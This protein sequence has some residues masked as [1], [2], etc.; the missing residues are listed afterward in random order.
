MEEQRQPFDILFDGL[1][2][3]ESNG[4]HRDRAGNLTNSNLPTDQA[5]GITQVRVSTGQDP[6]FGV[7]PI[8]NDSEEEY[9]RFGRDYLGAM[10]REYDNDPELAL[11]AYNAGTG[12][13]N[14]AIAEARARGGSWKEYLPKPSETLPYIDKIMNYVRENMDVEGDE[15]GFQQVVSSLEDL[16]EDAEAGEEVTADLDG[17]ENLDLSGVDAEQF[18]NDIDAAMENIRSGTGGPE[19][20]TDPETGQTFHTFPRPRED[21]HWTDMHEDGAWLD[22]SELLYQMV[23]G[24]PPFTEEFETD[25]DMA[26]WGLWYMSR[27]DMQLSTLVDLAN[28][29]TRRGDLE[30][31][32]GLAYMIEQSNNI[33]MSWDGAWR[34]TKA[35]AYDPVNWLSLTSLIGAPVKLAAQQATKAG[36]V[37]MLKNSILSRTTGILAVEA[38]A[39]NYAFDAMKQ[40]VELQVGLREDRDYWQ[41]SRSGGIGAVFGGVGGTVADLVATR[42][43]RRV[44]AGGSPRRVPGKKGKKGETAEIIPTPQKG[45]RVEDDVI[46]G[47]QPAS[48]RTLEDMGLP[49][50][51]IQK[52]LRDTPK[53]L[54]A[55]RNIAREL[56]TE[57][58]QVPKD[59]IPMVAEGI[60]RLD[61]GPETMANIALSVRQT[62]HQ[63]NMERAALIQSKLKAVASNSI[64][65]VKV[66]QRQLDEL[67]AMAIPLNMMDEAF[68]SMA[69]STLRQRVGFGPRITVESV[70]KEFPKKTKDEAEAIWNAAWARNAADKKADVIRR[71]MADEVDAALARGD[72][73]AA[74]SLYAR[75]ES[76]ID[77]LYGEIP[78]M[79][80]PFGVDA[81]MGM[82]QHDLLVGTETMRKLSEVATANVFSP[83]TLYINI[84]PSLVKTLL[85]PAINTILK[86]PFRRASYVEA[87]ANYQAMASATGAAM[88]MAHMSFKFESLILTRSHVRFL[89][90]ELANASRLTKL[91]TKNPWH[92]FTQAAPGAMRGILRAMAA[93]DD[94][95]SMVAHNGHIAGRVTAEVYSDA[96]ANGATSRAATRLAKKKVAKALEQ[97]ATHRELDE[98]MNIILKKGINLGYRG[99]DL[100]TYATREGKDWAKHMRKYKDED[101]RTYIMDLMYKTEFEVNAPMNTLGGAFDNSLEKLGGMYDKLAKSQ[102]HWK[103]LLGQLF[104]KTPYRAI[105]EGLRLTPG[106]QLVTP[107]FVTDLKGHN[108]F[109]AQMRAQSEH[110]LS[111][112]LGG[113][114]IMKFAQA[115]IV[116]SGLHNWKH[117]VLLQDSAEADPYTIAFSDGD[118]WSYRMFDPIATPFKVMANALERMD[119]IRMREAQG[120]FVDAGLLKKELELF[121]AGVFSITRAIGDANL[122]TGFR[123]FT[124]LFQQFDEETGNYNKAVKYVAERVRWALP[125]SVHN[126]YRGA[127]PHLYDPKTFAQS[128]VVATGP[129]GGLVKQVGSEFVTVPRAYDIMGFARTVTDTGAL[130]SYLSTASR[131]DREKGR[132]EQALRVMKGLHQLSQHTGAEFGAVYQSPLTGDLDLR[133][134]T[135]GSGDST[136]YDE[137]NRIYNSM[138]PW[139]ELDMVLSSGLAEGTM[140]QRSD[141]VKEAQGIISEYRSAAFDML[142]DLYPELLQA[143]VDAETQKLEVEAGWHDWNR[144]ENSPL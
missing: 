86:D 10:F 51:R 128:M 56:A 82:S 59:Q 34:G 130:W 31:M 21:A 40:T 7:R 74:V 55:A 48:Q 125:A 75:R 108:G 61:L 112:A 132:P 64:P 43:A 107:R 116:G 3:A 98:R 141:K 72:W 25:E 24:R 69:G 89:E 92:R 126:L 137:W 41:Q 23:Y 44:Q 80:R 96:I 138:E 110:L 85:K 47:G 19:T 102:P 22:A 1:I 94:F 57:L 9:L 91:D 121:K 105:E 18:Q 136:L 109:R 58:K 129:L 133:T 12:N 6:G 29:I 16:V 78:S 68:G 28:I 81:K 103:I 124:E 134:L 77:D 17:I 139:V 100:M 37:H 99:R 42:F 20:I 118:T 14:R 63:L 142:L 120:E 45:R 60:R 15:R 13:V 97:K 106:L 135:T 127:D 84:I 79:Y 93:S 140:S 49:L 101:V 123:T 39:Y 66:L 104:F 119:N 122:F 117:R 53:D 52:G 50:D 113:W 4:K 2:Q 33:D 95:L 114:F 131:E 90:A 30:A 88:R 73:D 83:K 36:V 26:N 115:E 65:D 35:L 67:E 11:A 8:E 62:S 143:H 87:A 144:L 5:L 111:V 54:T 32:M 27:M 70:M 46:P 38:G 71:E 76:L